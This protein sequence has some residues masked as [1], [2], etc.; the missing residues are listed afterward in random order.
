MKGP[1][2]F[3]RRDHLRTIEHNVQRYWASNRTFE[4][5]Y[6]PGKPKYFL[7]FPYPYMNGRL[8]LGHAF[9]YC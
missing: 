4:A 9:R 3:T 7:N 8:H 6:Q 5:N 1:K 2:K